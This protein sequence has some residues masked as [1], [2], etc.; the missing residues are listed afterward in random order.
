M[1]LAAKCQDWVEDVNGVSAARGRCLPFEA[2]SD[3]NTDPFHQWLKTYQLDKAD[4][5]RLL[6][7]VGDEMEQRAM[8][9][10]FDEHW[11]SLENEEMTIILP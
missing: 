10:G 8:R 7:Q 2:W 5:E 3:Q 1:L 6:G 11:D 4:L 9:A